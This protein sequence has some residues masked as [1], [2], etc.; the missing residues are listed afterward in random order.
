M[1]GEL[2][3]LGGSILGN[4]FANKAKEKE[5]KQQKEFAQSGIQWKVQDAEKAGIHP[6]YALGANTVSYSPQ[7]VGGGDYSYMADAGQNIGRAIDATRSNP[8]RGAA[9]ALTAVQLEGLQLDNDIKRAQLNSALSLARQPGTGPG[10]P[11]TATN[12]VIPGQGNTPQVDGPSI[13]LQK[14]ISPAN[15]GQPSAEYGEVPDIQYAR[16]STGW[17]PVMPQQI[18]ESFEQDAVGGLQWQWRNKYAPG[19]MKSKQYANP[20]RH[21]KLPFGTQWHYNIGAGEWQIQRSREG[22]A[23]RNYWQKRTYR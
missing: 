13:E 10:L 3:S 11:S 19:I 16:T 7:S 17:A 15:T 9:T 8:A 23:L 21:V 2:L 1:L 6:L 4:V 14:K 18:A 12:S 20:P 5:Y 22:Q